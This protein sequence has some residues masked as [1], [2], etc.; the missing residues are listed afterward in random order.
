MEFKLTKTK[1]SLFLKCINELTPYIAIVKREK[2]YIL[3]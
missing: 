1:K 3:K 2:Q